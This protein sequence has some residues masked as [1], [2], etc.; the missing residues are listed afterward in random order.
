METGNPRTRATFLPPGLTIL[1]AW[2]AV[3]HRMHLLRRQIA[4]LVAVPILGLAV[5][6][7]L[8]IANKGKEEPAAPADG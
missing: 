8:A 6:V 1:K 2:S 7:Q 5:S 4:L 3:I